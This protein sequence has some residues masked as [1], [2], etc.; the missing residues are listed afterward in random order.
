MP[1]AGYRGTKGLGGLVLWVL[2]L[3]VRALVWLVDASAHALR[4]G[5]GRAKL[6]RDGQDAIYR[7][8]EVARE[9]N[10]TYQPFEPRCGRIKGLLGRAELTVE[11]E[12]KDSGYE[13]S[14]TTCVAL[15][16]R[17]PL[18]WVELTPETALTRARTLLGGQDLQLGDE[19][20]DRQ[21]RV[22][23][24]DEARAR[25]LL[26]PAARRALLR[27]SALLPGLELSRSALRLREPGVM[28]N[29]RLRAALRALR[30]AAEA[31][32][33]AHQALR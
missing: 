1:G 2:G 5:R 23:S 24:Q 8:D 11:P 21:F 31:L 7:W 22:Q 4:L 27:A 30:E 16:L 20:F 13:D 6:L 9:H 26:T 3:P 15:H 25:A 29:A 19:G 33:D 17:A 28:S 14:I 32:Q 10:L 12:I 18:S